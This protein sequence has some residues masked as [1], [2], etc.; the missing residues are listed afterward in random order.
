MTDGPIPCFYL[1]IGG[2]ETPQAAI[3]IPATAVF[4]FPLE[5]RSYER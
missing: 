3:T 4:R 2:W 5:T 1:A